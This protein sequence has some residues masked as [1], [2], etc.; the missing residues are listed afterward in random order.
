MKTIEQIR[1]LALAWG[2]YLPYYIFNLERP[3]LL[4][5]FL[6]IISLF[7]TIYFGITFTK[8]WKNNLKL[9]GFE[10]ERFYIIFLSL[11]FLFLIDVGVH[12]ISK[13]YLESKMYDY[14]NNGI[15][16]ILFGIFISVFVGGFLNHC[17]NK[18]MWRY[19][20]IKERC[21]KDSY[22]F[23]NLLGTFERSWHIL[24]H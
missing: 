8:S 6:I 14:K 10:H 13:G 2:F 9:G 12:F 15:N 19:L 3:C 18:L 1:W 11:N 21:V 22:S 17:L 23:V 24:L 16:L 20:S 7:L 5:P 4:F